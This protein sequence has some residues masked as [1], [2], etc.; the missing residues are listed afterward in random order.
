MYRKLVWGLGAV[1]IAC[2][3]VAIIGLATSSSHRWVRPAEEL[4]WIIFVSIVIIQYLVAPHSEVEGGYTSLQMLAWALGIVSIVL[5]FFALISNIAISGATPKWTEA[6]EAVGL[7]CM[8]G[9]VLISISGRG[10]L[11]GGD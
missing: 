1:A 4:G 5:L 8:L 7:L 2:F 9:L 6:V 10:K 3:I 11:W